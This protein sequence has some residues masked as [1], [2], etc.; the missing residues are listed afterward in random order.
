MKRLMLSGGLSLGVAMA[1]LTSPVIAQ[2]RDLDPAA[3]AAATR[4]GLPHGFD[5]FMNTCFDALEA[6]AYSVVNADRLRAKFSD[7]AEASW[8]GARLLLIQAV[9]EDESG[10]A[11]VISDL[12]DDELRPFVNGFLR[13]MAEQE[14][15]QNDCSAID[16]ALEIFDPMPADNLAAL[17]GFIMELVQDERARERGSQ[18]V[19]A[20]PEMTES[21][22]RKLR[23]Q[24]EEAQRQ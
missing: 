2:Q 7:G 24:E 8:P 6:D 12:E 23:E 16:R 4:Y 19:T 5:G 13:N 21:R 9:E 15:N 14:I 11:N 20:V 18:T 10:A 1:L 22:R 17:I 3:V